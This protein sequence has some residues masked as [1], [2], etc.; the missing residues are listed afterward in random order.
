MMNDERLESKNLLVNMV[1]GGTSSY[2]SLVI[3][4]QINKVYTFVF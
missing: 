1:L 2:S 3:N 4:K